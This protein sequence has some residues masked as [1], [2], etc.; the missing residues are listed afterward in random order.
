MAF[1]WRKW[2]NI[3][4]RDLGYLFV[5]MTLIYAISGIALNHLADWNPNYIIKNETVSVSIPVPET[6]WTDDQIQQWLQD[7]GQKSR[8][9]SHYWPQPGFLR[10][11]IDGGT[12]TVDLASRQASLEQVKC[13]P[14]FFKVNFLHYNNPRQLWTWFADLFCVVLIILAITGLFVLKGRK[15]IKGRG[16][17]LTGI[18][19]LAPFFFLV[20]Y[21]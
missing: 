7:N 1:K 4:H 6:G 14:L 21:L 13:R 10:I 11:F 18:G 17:W 8:Y 9:K 5:G 2:N 16:A 20:Y 19:I 12:F 15:G 3:L